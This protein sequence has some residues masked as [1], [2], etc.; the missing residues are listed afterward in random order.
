VAT[1]YVVVR[2]YWER[3]GPCPKCKANGGIPC[4]RV[5][6]NGRGRMLGGILARPHTDRKLRPPRLVV[7]GRWVSSDQAAKKHWAE[8]QYGTQPLC[9]TGRTRDGNYEYD[10]AFV[11]DKPACS[12][13]ST[14][15]EIQGIFDETPDA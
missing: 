15:M 4:R 12:R 6:F 7:K 10:I 14:M 2:A 5:V 8:G 9:N 3:Y 1:S 11:G 13:C